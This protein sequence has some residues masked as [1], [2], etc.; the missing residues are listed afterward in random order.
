MR[1]TT[2][3][4][5]VLVGSTLALAACSSGSAS[6][7]GGS[8]SAAPSGSNK[9]AAASSGEP[10]VAGKKGHKKPPKD[11]P[12][13]AKKE[14]IKKGSA[15][16]EAK[17]MTKGAVQTN[18]KAIKA[19]EQAGGD[20]APKKNAEA[21]S[22]ACKDVPDLAA[23]CSVNKVLF[24]KGGEEWEFDCDENARMTGHVGG[25]CI[26]TQETV[27]CQNYDYETATPP[28]V[29]T[30]CSYDE[31]GNPYYCCDISSDGS[32]VCYSL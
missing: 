16:E 13:T 14:L 19:A 1:T 12:A 22:D 32:S 30:S 4:S 18:E 7:T 20:A 10:K 3:A 24:C 6:T 27:D 2:F 29:Y 17:P 9:A 5:L 25:T 23:K 28:E 11:R 21:P 31:E 26:E 8:S 15:D